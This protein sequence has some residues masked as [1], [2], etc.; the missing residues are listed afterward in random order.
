MGYISRGRQPLVSR[1]YSGW[2]NVSC[3]RGNWR[4]SAT[5]VIDD[6]DDN[7]DDEDEDADIRC[8]KSKI[9]EDLRLS[10]K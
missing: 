9:M 8:W 10:R 4:S 2:I 6:D 3:R 7:N 5:D 1:R